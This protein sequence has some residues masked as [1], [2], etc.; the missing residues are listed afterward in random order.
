MTPKRPIELVNAS[1]AIAEAN[2]KRDAL[3]E[4]ND[5]TGVIA[6]NNAIDILTE[7]YN[8]IYREWQILGGTSNIDSIAYPEPAIDYDHADYIDQQRTIE[9][10]RY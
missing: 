1:K 2:A 9:D 6:M 8:T 3:I 4:A 5:R 10:A 7:R